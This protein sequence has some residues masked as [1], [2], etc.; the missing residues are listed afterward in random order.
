MKEKKKLA[1]NSALTIQ[2]KKIGKLPTQHGGNY[3]Y[4]YWKLTFDILNHKRD[5]F[6]KKTTIKETKLIVDDL[7]HNGKL[8]SLDQ[9]KPLIEHN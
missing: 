3:P 5:Q 2:L 4:P 6:N 1:E 7:P 9:N 8:S